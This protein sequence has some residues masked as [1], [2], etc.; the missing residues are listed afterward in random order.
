MSV[1]HFY[2]SHQLRCLTPIANDEEAR[3]TAG[4]VHALWRS[5]AELSWSSYLPVVWDERSDGDRFRNAT[6]GTWEANLG[7]ELMTD[8]PQSLQLPMSKNHWVFPP[9]CSLQSIDEETLRRAAQSA[10]RGKTGRSADSVRRLATTAQAIDAAEVAAACAPQWS[11]L[12]RR[13]HVVVGS[14][15][16]NQE[17]AACEVMEIKEDGVSDTSICI[18]MLLHANAA[19]LAQHLTPLSASLVCLSCL[20]MMLWPLVCKE[21]GRFIPR[22]PA[23]LCPFASISLILPVLEEQLLAKPALL[24]V[25]T[26]YSHDGYQDSNAWNGAYY[27]ASYSCMK[28]KKIKADQEGGVENDKK[29]FN[30]TYAHEQCVKTTIAL[31]PQQLREDNHARVVPA[32]CFTRPLLPSELD[33]SPAAAAVASS[34]P[35]IRRPASESVAHGTAEPNRNQSAARA[36]ASQAP[37]G[38]GAAAAGGPHDRAASPQNAAA[39]VEAAPAT[40]AAVPPSAAALAASASEPMDIDAGDDDWSGSAEGEQ[41]Q[42]DGTAATAARTATVASPATLS[43]R[44]GVTTATTVPARVGG[45]AAAGGPARSSSPFALANSLQPACAADV[46]PRVANA[47]AAAGGLAVAVADRNESPAGNAAAPSSSLSDLLSLQ[48]ASVRALELRLV[49]ALKQ[50]EE[51]GQEKSSLQRQ[52]VAQTSLASQKTAEAELMR[53]EHAESLAAQQREADDLRR[54]L[55]ETHSRHTAELQARDAQLAAR[56]AQLIELER[57]QTDLHADAANAKARVLRLQSRSTEDSIRLRELEEQ[58]ADAAAA[59]RRVAELQSK[60]RAETEL[61]EETKRQRGAGAGS[62]E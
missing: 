20:Q 17:A 45:A 16:L 58:A 27:P 2:F 34:S 1:P 32:F 55:T 60:R 40:A 54:Q 23:A 52:L 51:H 29:E 56:E 44:P 59:S 12:G 6:D 33:A 41:K 10:P 22:P 37:S 43:Q 50:V 39:R 25:F 36:L 53:A 8:A 47:A 14:L 31:E 9:F 57:K 13:G 15:V 48:A 11:H 26:L 62:A 3:L 49:A 38:A 46:V 28:Q 21:G 35:S 19:H 18:F 42:P 5:D 30:I 4:V 61:Q 7:F 24:G